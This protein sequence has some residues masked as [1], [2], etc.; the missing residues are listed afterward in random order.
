MDWSDGQ[1][2]QGQAVGF[3]QGLW[4]KDYPT[5][6]PEELLILRDQFLGSSS[7]CPL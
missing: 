2:V 3:D 4:T 1:M 5:N 6:L 7:V